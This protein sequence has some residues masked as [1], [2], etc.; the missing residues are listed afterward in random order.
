[1]RG[2]GGI[3]CGCQQVRL[4]SRAGL[5]PVEGVRICRP[6]ETWRAVD[7]ACWQ[8]AEKDFVDSEEG[9]PGMAC[10]SSKEAWQAPLLAFF[11][12]QAPYSPRKGCSVGIWARHFGGVL[13]PIQVGNHSR[14]APFLHNASDVEAGMA[15]NG[16]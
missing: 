6:N 3:P 4:A 14:A 11:N 5:V 10:A 2:F 1:M 12:W 13:E 9:D 7:P 8:G 15:T 16:G